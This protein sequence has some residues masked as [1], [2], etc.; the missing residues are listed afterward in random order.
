[1]YPENIDLDVYHDVSSG[2]GAPTHHRRLG[3]TTDL[4]NSEMVD[5]EKTWYCCECKEGPMVRKIN[6]A[7]CE[8]GHQLC[9]LCKKDKSG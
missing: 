9:P 1:M 4:Y 3:H 5:E 7:C 8:C 6:P 2:E